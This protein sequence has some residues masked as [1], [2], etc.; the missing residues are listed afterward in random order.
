MSSFHLNLGPSL[1]SDLIFHP[2]LFYFLTSKYL[3]RSYVGVTFLQP[4][5][6][7]SELTLGFV[8]M[9]LLEVLIMF[10]ASVLALK[11]GHL[12]NRKLLMET[13]IPA[14]I[15]PCP[16]SGQ[17]FRRIHRGTIQGSAMILFYPAGELKGGTISCLI[18]QKQKN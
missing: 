1:W 15:F 10:P 11:R 14:P 6:V 7:P 3:I 8:I 2:S 18:K 12:T 17:Y 13:P 4:I 5:F 9:N 16:L